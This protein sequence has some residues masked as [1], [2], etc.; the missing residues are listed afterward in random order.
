MSA[1]IIWIALPLGFALILLILP[2]EKWVSYLGTFFSFSLAILAFWIP[3]DTA[4]RLGSISIKI[5]PGFALLGRTIS[6]P[7]AQQIILIFA[8]GIGAFWFFGTTA[9]GN[10]KKIIPFGMAIISLLVASIAV[11]PFLYAAFFIEI[12]VI[13]SIPMLAES[14]H[15][16]TKGLLRFLI[17]QSLAMPFILL[18][19]FLLTGV[20]AGPSDIAL[21]SQ[22]A[23][24]LGLGFAF[25][26]S[27]FPLYTWMP[28]MLE[29]HHPYAVGFILTIF[30][31][32]HLIF[33]LNFVDRFSW[34]RDSAS[35]H[36]ILQNLGLLMIITAGAWAAFQRHIGRIF[37]YAV[38]LETGISL[39][40]LSIPG[41]VT[42][43]QIAFYLIIPHAIIFAVWTQSISILK[44]NAPELTFSQ[45]RG[46]ARQFPIASIGLVISNLTLA[47]IPLFALF[48]IRQ[49]LWEQ[50]A[51]TSTTTA[52]WFG[53]AN[54]GIW[55]A[56]LRSLAVL[57]QAPED[58]LW[59]INESWSQRILIGLG[60][61]VIFAQGFYPQWAEPFLKKLPL[62]F[63]HLGK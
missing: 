42:G 36:T 32:F 2:W 19:G 26:L 43:L 15:K 57:T 40:A 9:L 6:I 37:A 53:L 63:E 7:N 38:A 1:P 25:L 47:G 60:V 13:L 20:E 34:L 8:Y 35:L 49:A 24:L 22:S 51:A 30:P 45:L 10:G 21:I 4:Q 27:I 39:L 48:P 33:G 16:P 52:L 54:L 31:T 29:E 18:A 55:V 41:T 3:P 11:E 12:A 50:L 28:M 59:K 61:L 62:F 58:T 44:T 5:D 17:Y 14:V 23:F 56:A 46:L